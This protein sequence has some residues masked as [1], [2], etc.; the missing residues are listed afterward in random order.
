MTCAI[1]LM[2]SDMV[3]ATFSMALAVVGDRGADLARGEPFPALNLASMSVESAMALLADSVLIYRCWIVYGRSWLVASPLIIFWM[4]GVA[5]VLFHFVIP[6]LARDPT[7]TQAQVDMLSNQGNND[8]AGFFACTI[9]INIFATTAIIVRIW[10]VVKQNLSPR[11]SHSLLL[12]IRVIAD[13]GLL[14]TL[15]TISSLITWVLNSKII[16]EAITVAQGISLAM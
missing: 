11:P 5:S 7:Q 12:T 9:A 10:Q 6:L 16:T 8:Q 3:I 2:M 1:C 14:Y 13:S 4:G 15:T